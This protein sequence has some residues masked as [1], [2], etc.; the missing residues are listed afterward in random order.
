M[1]NQK[2]KSEAQAKGLPSP[3]QPVNRCEVDGP[4]YRAVSI[5]E[6]GAP[7]HV[8]ER[9]RAELKRQQEAAGKPHASD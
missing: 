8:A 3:P 9:I 1:E 6:Y 5:R 7:P 4:G 2:P